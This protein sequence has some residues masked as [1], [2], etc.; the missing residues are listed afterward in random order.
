MSTTP[1]I[2]VV[3]DS[4]VDFDLICW[5]LRQNG[6]DS[7]V[8]RAGT[9]EAALAALG[10]RSGSP[11]CTKN[12]LP[13]LIIVDINMPGMGGFGLLEQLKQHQASSEIPVV[14]MSASSNPADMAISYQ[15]GAACFVRKPTTLGGYAG[16]MGEV[17]KLLFAQ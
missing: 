15:R 2:L 4:E 9:A 8:T 7:P 1:H 10:V 13:Y 3:D 11:K 12:D 14:I 16:K 17:M 6:I 5:G